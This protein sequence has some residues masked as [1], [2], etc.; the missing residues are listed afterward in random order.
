M[1]SETRHTHN[2]LRHQ[3]DENYSDAR[4]L[5]EDRWSLTSFTIMAAA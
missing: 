2:R 4:G 1:V 5:K 3:R